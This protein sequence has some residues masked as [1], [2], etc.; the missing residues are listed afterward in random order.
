MCVKEMQG[1]TDNISVLEEERACLA[2]ILANITSSPEL[3][4]DYEELEV[5]RAKL[6]YQERVFAEKENNVSSKGKKS[7]QEKVQEIE[8]ATA[9]M[10]KEAERSEN[11]E[12]ICLA[13][14]KIKNMREQEVVMQGQNFVSSFKGIGCYNSSLYA[15]EHERVLTVAALQE[16]FKAG[17]EESVPDW[18]DATASR[19]FLYTGS[20][21][22]S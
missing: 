9:E 11:M 13:N 22:E 2:T 19:V 14:D 17:V 18:E 16:S 12:K 15:L 6:A 8:R 7:L 5:M 21:F 10:I 3:S 20:E 4:Q 1:H